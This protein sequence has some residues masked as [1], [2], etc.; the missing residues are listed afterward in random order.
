MMTPDES[1]IDVAANSLGTGLQENM[2]AHRTAAP[3]AIGSVEVF[4]MSVLVFLFAE[5]RVQSRTTGN[6]TPVNER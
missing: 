1:G 5:E 2:F 4:M 3:I 6:A